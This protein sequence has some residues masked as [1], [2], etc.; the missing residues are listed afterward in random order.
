MNLRDIK[1]GPRLGLGFGLILLASSAMLV[2]TLVSN[3]ASRSALLDTLQKAGAQQDLAVEM[4]DSLLSSAVS[5]R[6][7]G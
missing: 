3:G 7:M 2:G 6:N 1:I 5:V 4:R